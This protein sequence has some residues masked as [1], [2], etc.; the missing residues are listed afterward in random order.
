[1][2]EATVCVGA[3]TMIPISAMDRHSVLAVLLRLLNL[4]RILF[5]F[6]PFCFAAQLQNASPPC[7]LRKCVKLGAS[8]VS[9]SEWAYTAV[10]GKSST[11]SSG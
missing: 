6:G 1:M 7:A 11:M 9:C 2:V 10:L 5:H 4:L 3:V 8:R